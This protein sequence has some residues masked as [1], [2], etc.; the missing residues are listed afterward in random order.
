MVNDDAPLEPLRRR[1]K[2]M[3][4]DSGKKGKTTSYLGGSITA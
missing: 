3:E 2:E 1:S 4:M